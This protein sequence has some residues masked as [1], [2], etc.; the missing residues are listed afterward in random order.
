MSHTKQLS[1]LVD[2]IYSC[3]STFLNQKCC[4]SGSIGKVRDPCPQVS[5]RLLGLC[6]TGLRSSVNNNWEQCKNA[7]S[8]T[9]NCTYWFWEGKQPEH[10]DADERE[11][12][13]TEYTDED[14]DD[15]NVADG[16]VQVTL[17]V[18][19]HDFIFDNCH[20]SVFQHQHHHDQQRRGEKNWFNYTQVLFTVFTF[21]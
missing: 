12:I 19:Q 2:D 17:T 8:G 18:L 4:G 11:L 10:D 7:N 13:T 20:S 15:A 14:C 1:K 9:M 16:V 3:T 21:L 6:E 5:L